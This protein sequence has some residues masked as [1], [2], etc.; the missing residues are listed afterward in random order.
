M[1]HLYGHRVGSRFYGERLCSDEPERVAAWIMKKA[2]ALSIDWR[3]D[4]KKMVY[5]LRLA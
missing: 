1:E 4:G 3:L 5:V 2:H